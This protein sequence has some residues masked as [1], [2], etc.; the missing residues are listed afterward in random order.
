M[1]K[2]TSWLFDK[3]RT[4]EIVKCHIFHEERSMCELMWEFIS[5]NLQAGISKRYYKL[6]FSKIIFRDFDYMNTS[7]WLLLVLIQNA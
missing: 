3:S 7:Q 4:L 1:S 5:V 6:T 2:N